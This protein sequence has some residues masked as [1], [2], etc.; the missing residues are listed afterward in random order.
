MQSG[1]S[2]DNVPFFTTESKP[3]GR[4]YGHWTVRWWK[5]FL[6]TPKAL[7]PVADWSGK[8]AH[9]NQPSNSVWFLAGKVASEDKRLP[10]RFCRIPTGRS[11]LFPVINYEANQLEF[12]ELRTFGD[13]VDRVRLE[14]DTIAEKTCSI[15][16]VCIPPQRVRSDPVIFR[17]R[18]RED[19][20]ANVKV[21][22]A[23]ASADGYWVFLKPLLPGNYVITFRGSCK[24]GRICSGARYRVEI[25]G[26]SRSVYD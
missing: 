25:S 21:G 12:P 6:S 11:I 26:D 16:E 9:V 23:Y 5:W 10:S 7:N 17:L 3:Y 20:I 2:I 1:P 18:L 4:T 15:D 22:S 13:I 24:Y 8:L 14:E 19:N